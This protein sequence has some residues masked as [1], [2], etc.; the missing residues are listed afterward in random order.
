[1][2]LVEHEYMAE[3]TFGKPWTE[4]HQWLDEFMGTEKYKTR[5]RRVRHHLEGI[6]QARKLF[7]NEGAEVAMQHILADLKLDGWKESDPF[8]KNE[9]HFVEMRLW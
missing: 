3:Q 5:H 7:G 2:K 8:P 6:E 4:V 1:M 9:K